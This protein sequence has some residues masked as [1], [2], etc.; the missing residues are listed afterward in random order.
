MLTKTINKLIFEPKSF[1]QD[2][3]GD[4]PSGLPFLF[5]A[6][7]LILNALGFWLLARGVVLGQWNFRFDLIMLGFAALLIVWLAFTLTIWIVAWLLRVR[8][9]LWTLIKASAYASMPFAIAWVPALL[10]AAA[11]TGAPSV[12]VKVFIWLI[13]AFLL[14]LSLRALTAA[15]KTGYVRVKR[16]KDEGKV[17]RRFGI[18]LAVPVLAAIAI[19][20]V[21]W[22]L[23]YHGTPYMIQGHIVFGQAAGWTVSDGS[24]SNNIRVLADSESPNSDEPVRMVIE[25]DQ[26]QQGDNIDTFFNTFAKQFTGGTLISSGSF[27]LAGMDAR[28]GVVQVQQGDIAVVMTLAIG[29]HGKSIVFLV[30]QA[31]AADAQRAEGRFQA[32]YDNLKPYEHTLH[33]SVPGLLD[34]NYYL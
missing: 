1:F 10:A 27:D 26:L 18:A 4:M 24:I 6:L 25:V 17:S 5:L 20:G 11:K 13:L 30:G 21:A 7:T 3:A 14:N 19:L 34:W 29:E 12:V 33:V 28:R 23:A 15:V 32:I 31:T 22:G 16:T 2:D 9:G 8:L